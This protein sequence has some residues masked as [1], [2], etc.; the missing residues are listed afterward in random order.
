MINS[1]NELIERRANYK[2]A[3]DAQT[4][5]ILI[6]A[7]TGCVAGG[8]LDIYDELQNIMQSKGIHCAVELEAEPHDNTV[9]LKRSGCHGFC[10][11]GPI[12]R[13]EPQGWLY[14]KVKLE[15]CADIIEMSIEHDELVE[16]LVYKED[17]KA[18]PKQED[19]PFY[20]KQ[21]R[22]VLENCGRID[23]LSIEE[24]IAK[25]G[26]AAT[27][28]AL[29]ELSTDDI[30]KAEADSLPDANGSRLRIS[31]SLSNTLSATVTRATPA[32]LWTEV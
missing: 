22:N 31:A 21:T 29:F 1:R 13:L 30:V 2:E 3:L 14:L 20:R 5:K 32:H 25:G 11:M 15:D 19:I 8:A 10:E 4:K 6:C 23:A 17:Q 9:G 24:Y 16:R 26:Y 28:K 12:V 7:G 18:Y 27:E